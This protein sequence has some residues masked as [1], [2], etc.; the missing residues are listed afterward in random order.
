MKIENLNFE[1]N[2]E[3]FVKIFGKKYS[4]TLNLLAEQPHFSDEF[5]YESRI[6]ENPILSKIGT[7]LDPE[8]T[9]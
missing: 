2:G 8:W 6:W 5:H 9:W 3:N 1:S 4:E 7:F